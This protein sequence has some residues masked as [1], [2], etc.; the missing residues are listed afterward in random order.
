MRV[1]DRDDGDFNFHVYSFWSPFNADSTRFIVASGGT[2][3]VNLYALDPENFTIQKLGNL[4]GNVLNR[5]TVLRYG[6]LTWSAV[7]PD[8][9]YGTGVRVNDQGLYQFAANTKIRTSPW[10]SAM[11]QTQ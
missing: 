4:Y 10:P 9:L 5:D 11:V 3:F 6:G 1:T 8:I 7:D 2:W